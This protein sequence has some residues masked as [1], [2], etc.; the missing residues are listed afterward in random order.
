ME[1]GT[2]K[3][4]GWQ[5]TLALAVL[6]LVF[7]VIG[8]RLFVQGFR[9]YE[10][11]DP[12]SVRYL[13]L[14]FVLPLI[15][16]LV[17]FLAMFSKAKRDGSVLLLYSY[18]L[19]TNLIATAVCYWLWDE[20]PGGGDYSIFA[21]V[22]IHVLLA[23][24]G[25]MTY[26][27]MWTPY[28]GVIHPSSRLTIK[29]VKCDE[30]CKKLRERA[31]VSVSNPPFN[32]YKVILSLMHLKTECS[33]RDLNQ[34]DQVSPDEV[35]EDLNRIIP[36]KDF[37]RSRDFAELASELKD[38]KEFQSLRSRHRQLTDME[39]QRL[40]L[41]LL[42]ACFP[43]AITREP[44][45]WYRRQRNKMTMFREG[46]LAN[47]KD[48]VS[49]TPFWAVVFFFTI[50]LGIT[51][52]FG[53]AFA[54]HDRE[55]IKTD[56]RV[57]LFMD[58]SIPSGG[59]LVKKGEENDKPQAN[60]SPSP[61]TFY[62]ASNSADFDRK[63]LPVGQNN[64][65]EER[66]RE[67]RAKKNIEHLQ[68]LVTAIKDGTEDGKGVRVRIVGA[69]D[70]EPV[71]QGEAAIAR[72]ASNYELSEA[73]AQNVK[74]VLMHKFSTGD[75]TQ[76]KVE[77][78][79]LPQSSEPISLPREQRDGEEEERRRAEEQA[80]AAKVT[81]ARQTQDI[82]DAEG[83][84]KELTGRVNRDLYADELLIS[85]LN[86]I[87]RLLGSRKLSSD[88][89]R[90]I[91]NKVN[92][93]IKMKS[94]TPPQTAALE[95]VKTYV[96]EKLDYFEY[97]DEKAQRRVV[98]VFIEP[99]DLNG[100]GRELNLLDY[101]YF[102]VYTITTTG[103]GDIV[104]TTPRAKYLCSLANILEVFFFVVFFNALLTVREGRTGRGA[105]RRTGD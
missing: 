77:W 98:N 33:I 84:V 5:F 74:Y 47:L 20:F 65:E 35:V 46:I 100:A 8:G 40:N 9:H 59:K 94:S 32:P 30:V 72:Y 78:L 105:L 49:K 15:G 102:T 68:S 60:P 69:T 38:N 39:V 31:G 25:L 55:S 27:I 52:L 75:G 88:N 44:P 91:T 51:Y 92:D 76:R 93:I 3:S 70:A 37:Y 28:K 50:F 103:Y 34:L 63:Y 58:E 18:Y 22:V 81:Q 99:V 89:A 66:S 56:G 45:G 29:N 1:E 16:Q 7:T 43:G 2:Q 4:N 101:M 53:F 85:R 41:L 96:D 21:V 87:G 71:G 42:E 104:P 90:D 95:Q 48:G 23:P 17:S 79:C 80:A 36:D 14:L 82:L 67:W 62:F 54:F 83:R 86:R 24:V 73:R 11:L 64:D 6:T 97:V 61:V 13:A 10:A 57:A 19:G 26:I 12:G